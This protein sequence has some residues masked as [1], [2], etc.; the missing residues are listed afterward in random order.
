[1]TNRPAPAVGVLLSVAAF[2]LCACNGKAKRELAEFQT[3]QA[4]FGAAVDAL[5]QAKLD[6][7]HARYGEAVDGM[8]RL[9]RPRSMDE[10]LGDGPVFFGLTARAWQ[11]RWDAE[12]KAAVEAQLPDLQRR[13]AAGTLDWSD[14]RAFLATYRPDLDERW[15]SVV[16][17]AAKGQLQ[18][19]GDVYV[20]ECE[21]A[22]T[23]EVCAALRAALPAKLAWP[24]TDEKLL[25]SDARAQA[26]GFVRVNA[27]FDRERVYANV[28]APDQNVAYALPARLSVVLTIESHRG[29]TTWD[30]DTRIQFEAEPPTAVSVDSL[31]STEN[32]HYQAL[33]DGVVAQVVARAKQ[34]AR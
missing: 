5:K 22:G 4:K 20:F 34:A 14:A 26:F 18:R 28:K 15:Q 10:N 31:R 3:A 25:T 7:A 30:G 33:T 32:T 16:E 23:P 19:L 29:A 27:T 21:S 8:T 6:E 1:M 13:T 12:F 11:E 9:R 17:G 2:A 24:L